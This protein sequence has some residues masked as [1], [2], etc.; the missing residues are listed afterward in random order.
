MCLLLCVAGKHNMFQGRH[1]CAKLNTTKTHVRK[2][3]SDWSSFSSHGTYE[4]MMLILRIQACICRW[5]DRCINKVDWWL[6]CWKP[7]RVFAGCERSPCFACS[8]GMDKSYLQSK[9]DSQI[10]WCLRSRDA[11]CMKLKTSSSSSKHQHTFVLEWISGEK[12]SRKVGFGG[13]CWFCN[14]T[15]MVWKGPIFVT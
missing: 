9:I 15:P 3:R 8:A 7:Q 1:F 2:L 10:I 6:W 13:L 11:D 5:H 14:S 12:R 4:V